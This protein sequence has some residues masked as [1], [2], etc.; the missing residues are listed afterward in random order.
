MSA[1][2]REFRRSLERAASTDPQVRESLDAI[3]R[4]VNFMKTQTNKL[5]SFS[6]AE[7]GAAPSTRTATGRSAGTA[8]GTARR[9]PRVPSSEE[10][11]PFICRRCNACTAV[12]NG[13][14]EIVGTSYAHCPWVIAKFRMER[15]VDAHESGYAK[16]DPEPD[17]RK[18]TAYQHMCRSGFL[19]AKG[20]PAARLP[21]V[22]AKP[23][24][25][26][27]LLALAPHTPR[28]LRCCFLTPGGPATFLQPT[29]RTARTLKTQHQ[30]GTYQKGHGDWAHWDPL[31]KYGPPET[32]TDNIHKVG[33]TAM[34]VNHI[35]I[36]DVSDSQILVNTPHCTVIAGVF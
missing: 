34:Q 29:Q 19:G 2:R 11:M 9:T 4:R 33:D 18:E 6:A 26:A 13:V 28:S 12:A 30:R 10:L 35:V 8:R 21:P 7:L 25:A 27:A 20:N 17:P 24:C 32:A 5:S 15:Q 36:T 23:N 16:G 31:I 14:A 3:Y 22:R 1:D